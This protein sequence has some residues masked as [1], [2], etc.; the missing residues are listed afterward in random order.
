MI[1]NFLNTLIIL[2]H[3]DDEFAILPLLKKMANF[4]NKFIRLVYCAE[5]QKS[6]NKFVR[7]KENFAALKILGLEKVKTIYL[8]DFFEIN[9]TY[10]YKASKNIYNYLENLNKEFLIH[11]V[12]TLNYEGGHPDHDALALIVDKFATKYNVRAFYFPAYNPRKTLLIPL[13]VCKPLKAQEH[14]FQYK[15]YKR[16]CWIDFF[17]LFFIYKSEFSAFIKLLPLFIIQIFSR[18]LYYANKVNLETV[19]WKYSFSWNIYRID[20][21]E[22]DLYINLI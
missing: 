15:L 21:E 4:D 22:I 11:Q 1:E 14:F 10:L 6:L 17:P 19:I 8:N 13:S 16:F 20:R 9:G 3:I 2:P 5:R 12:L 18:K 7:R